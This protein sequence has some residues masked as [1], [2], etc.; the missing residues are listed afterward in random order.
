MNGSRPAVAT[1][2]ADKKT[3]VIDHP[4][5]YLSNSQNLKK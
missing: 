4:F 2:L 3:E 1:A 5:L